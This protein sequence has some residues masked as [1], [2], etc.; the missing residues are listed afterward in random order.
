[1]EEFG[2]CLL[3]DPHKCEILLKEVVYIYACSHLSV[4]P[5][6]LINTEM[7]LRKRLFV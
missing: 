1:M 6:H 4:S 5:S 7:H 3:I 2:D